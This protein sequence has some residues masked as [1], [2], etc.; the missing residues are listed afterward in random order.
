M[1][2]VCLCLSGGTRADV[3]SAFNQSLATYM[4][5]GLVRHALR[6]QIFCCRGLLCLDWAVHGKDAGKKF[7]RLS[8]DIVAQESLGPDFQ[9]RLESEESQQRRQQL[10]VCGNGMAE[11]EYKNKANTV[12]V[13]AT[14]ADLGRLWNSIQVKQ[15]VNLH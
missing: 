1:L 15:C 7:D 13:V 6:S 8:T 5:C 11:G 9:S 2:G 3:E 10:F 14:T 12:D 4:E